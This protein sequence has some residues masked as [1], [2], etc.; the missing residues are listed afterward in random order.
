MIVRCSPCAL[1]LVNQQ[2]EIL[3]RIDLRETA[4]SVPVIDTRSAG[5]ARD[6][7]AQKKTTGHKVSMQVT[8]EEISVLSHTASG[9][10]LHQVEVDWSGRP[11][12][13]IARVG[14]RKVGFQAPRTMF[15]RDDELLL[16]RRESV[17]SEY[18]VSAAAHA[19]VC[20][21]HAMLGE[22]W[23][24]TAHAPDRAQT[25]EQ[26]QQQATS[27]DDSHENDAAEH[28]RN[29]SLALYKIHNNTAQ[30]SA[31]HE[32]TVVLS[33]ATLAPVDVEEL[34]SSYFPCTESDLFAKDSAEVRVLACHLLRA[35]I[36]AQDNSQKSVITVA[37]AY[38]LLPTAADAKT[39]QRK[40]QY[41]FCARVRDVENAQHLS[42]SASEDQSNDDED[43]RELTAARQPSKVFAARVCLGEHSAEEEIPYR[44]I[45]Q[46]CVVIQ[47]AQLKVINL[48]ALA[49]QSDFDLSLAG[50]VIRNISLWR[51]TSCPRT[52]QWNC[53][54]FEVTEE[55]SD[56]VSHSKELRVLVRVR[57]P[58]QPIWSLAF[59]L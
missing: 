17:G 34:S 19:M 53:C 52:T 14:S 22:T 3:D 7:P 11:G 58:A 56:D 18:R 33:L 4:D 9:V 1:L 13:Q 30:R 27:S 46:Y 24:F 20:S 25:D 28:A 55:Q 51:F 49:A 16:Q 57:N 50:A 2:L 42:R 23:F 44:F 59:K 36:N 47:D 40:A 41:L 6:Q 21:T 10:V 38:A 54:D 5:A 39:A 26:Q 43:S 15:F 8:Q 32:A 12:F 37:M 29:T 31:E 35:E 45:S 48:H